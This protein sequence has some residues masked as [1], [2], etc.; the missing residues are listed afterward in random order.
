MSRSPE[1]ANLSGHHRTTLAAIFRHPMSHNIEWPD[2]LSLLRAIDAVRESR[3]GYEV[4]LGAATRT[5]VRTRDKDLAADDVA[6]LRRM[7]AEAGYRV[8]PD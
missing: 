2:V 7:L 1:S 3:E 4:S 8:D 5:F 6:H